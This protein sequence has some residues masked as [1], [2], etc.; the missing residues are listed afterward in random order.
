M[1]LKDP[2]ARPPSA[3]SRR[4]KPRPRGVAEPVNRRRIVVIGTSTGGVITLRDL[5]GGLSPDFP[6]PILVVMHLSPTHRSELPRIISKAGPLEAR[7]A[8]DG[9]PLAPGR[10]YVAPPDCHLL[11]EP[12]SVAV[13]HGPRENRFRPSID[14][15]FR[16]AAY[17]HGAGTIGVILSGALEDGVSGLWTIKRLGGI[18]IVQ[19]PSDAH[20]SYLPESAQEQVAV[21]HLA[22]A[23]DIGPLLNRLVADVMPEERPMKKDERKRLET[24]VRIAGGRYPLEEGS[25]ELG[26]ASMY[27]CPECH[28]VLMQLEEGGTK[29]FRCHTGHAYSEPALLDSINESVEAKLRE[30]T[31]A[32][33]EASLLMTEMGND[34][35]RKN[36]AAAAESLLAGARRAQARAHAL[37]HE[38]V[39]EDALPGR[40][41]KP[42]AKRGG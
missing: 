12:G 7:H 17:S 39:S 22:K 29:R 25:L 38:T 42:A 9:E 10:I 21:D 3:P 27:S 41:E 34:L 4:S 31:R 1:D 24:E 32:I 33:E 6:A 23:K 36:Q 40:M 5:A 14:A 15:L 20:M 18:S 16:S 19:D 8:V 11:V 28:G 35:A 30:A 2:V 26:K 37:Q 13:A